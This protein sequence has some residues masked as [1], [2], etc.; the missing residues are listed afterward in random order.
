LK[1]TNFSFRNPFNNNYVSYITDILQ[2]SK[3]HGKLRIYPR[4]LK[5]DYNSRNILYGAG[6]PSITFQWEYNNRV[7]A[8]DEVITIYNG[9]NQD[10][11]ILH[12]D[13]IPSESIT[14]VSDN[15]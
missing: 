8:S 9:A 14:I 6:E 15:D 11:P 10:L 3:I 13:G 1:F 5:E 2:L 4:K 7:P 12:F